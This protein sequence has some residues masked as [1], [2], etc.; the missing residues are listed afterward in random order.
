MQWTSEPYSGFSTAAPWLKVHPGYPNRN[1]AS[2]S[3]DPRSVLNF[4]K[5]LLR[6][7]RSHNAL[8]RGIFIPLN[9]EPQR[10]LAYLRQD[11]DSRI[12]VALNFARHRS[13]LALGGDLTR[14]HWDVLLSNK[15][16]SQT[17][18]EKGWLKLEGYEACILIQK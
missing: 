3:K 9:H 5:S 14:Y 18:F 4:Y 6:L 1:V 17:L 8:R 11:S 16:R 7:R 10:V 2:Q 15:N 13:R 12:L